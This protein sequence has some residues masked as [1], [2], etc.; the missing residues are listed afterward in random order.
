MRACAAP[1]T[2]VLVA[3]RELPWATSDG[4]DKWV[5]VSLA[6]EVLGVTRQSLVGWMAPRHQGRQEK[7]NYDVSDKTYN[8]RAATLPTDGAWA[9]VTR[10]NRGLSL[11]SDHAVT[12]YLETVSLKTAPKRDRRTTTGLTASER[13]L[14]RDLTRQPSCLPVWKVI[15][16]ARVE[17]QPTLG[18]TCEVSDTLTW[19][20]AL[21]G[22][23]GHGVS[24][25]DPEATDGNDVSLGS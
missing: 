14:I 16:D 3:L 8:A 2:S 18:G 15:E 13:K 21:A 9:H 5:P 12:E 1:D 19:L 10:S 24:P 6:A 25:M 7:R 17:L 11:I 4:K 22:A 20:T 23:L